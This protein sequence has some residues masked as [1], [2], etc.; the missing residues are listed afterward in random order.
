[1][2][3]M[4]RDLALRLAA[5][6]LQKTLGNPFFLIHYLKH[7]YDTNVL[8]FDPNKGVWTCNVDQVSAMALAENAAEL[9]I[10]AF[11]RMDPEVRFAAMFPA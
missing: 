9:M 2:S 3:S 8:R 11:Q 1:M 10:A 5:I 6:L 7:M 4:E